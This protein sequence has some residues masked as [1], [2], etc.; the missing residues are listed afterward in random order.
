[1]IH[2]MNTAGWC[3]DFY[4]AYFEGNGYNCITPDL[5][6]HDTDPADPPDTRLGTTGLLDYAADLEELIKELPGPPILMG[7]SMGGLLAQILATRLP[8]RALVLLSPAAP[9]GIIPLRLSVARCFRTGLLKWGWWRKPIRPTLREVTY[10]NLHLMPEEY[11]EEAYA[12]VGYESGRV[13]FQMG[14]WFLDKQRSSEV[15]ES[16]IGC[17]VLVVVGSEDRLTPAPVV[18]K[19]AK[20]YGA[21]ATFKKF[22]DHAHWIIGEPGWEEVAGYVAGW[23]DNAL[24]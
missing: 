1:M 10:S 6:Y 21:V 16:K 13:G 22:P 7:H 11:R 23:L 24:D 15:D 4:R 5:R 19:V 9:R 2:G 12:R 14:L 20:K 18:R 3:W 17:P 8:V